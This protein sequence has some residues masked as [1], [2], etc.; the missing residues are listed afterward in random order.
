MN[1]ISHNNFK[2]GFTLIELLVVIAII[3]LL[4]A[5]VLASL[6]SARSKGGDAAVRANLTGIRSQAELYQD[7]NGHY[8]VETILC[9]AGMFSADGNISRAVSEAVRNGGGPA[10][11]RSSDA[12]IATTAN[13]SSWAV[14]VPLKSNSAL[15]FCVD[16]SGN[17]TTTATGIS[18]TGGVAATTAAICL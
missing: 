3:G 10:L 11:C 4:S 14:R 15:F 13:A 9:T 7:T 12:T 16:S 8:G 2:A 6:N 17:A 5:V 18:I 1:K